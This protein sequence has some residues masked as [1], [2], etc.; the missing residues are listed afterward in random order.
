MTITYPYG[1]SLYVNVTNRCPN[2]CDFCIRTKADGFYSKD[3][4]LK[5]EPSREEI[6]ADL[7]TKDLSRYDAVVFCGYGEPTERLDDILFITRELKRFCPS[8]P[9]RLNTNGQSDLIHGRSTAADFENSFNILSISLN[10]PT[11][12]GYHTLCH[13]RYGE[14]ALPAILAFAREVKAYVPQV[15][16]SVVRGSIPDEEIEECQNIADRCEIPL[17]IREY[18]KN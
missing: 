5:R 4:W 11:P 17:R 14:K 16:F 8:L 2:R 10:A 6:L 15:V 13:S 3:L 9:I 7:Q 18:I 12:E 1:N